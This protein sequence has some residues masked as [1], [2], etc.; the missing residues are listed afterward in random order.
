M[1]EGKFGDNLLGE[2]NL[3]S[4][5]I[6]SLFLHDSFLNSLGELTI[7]GFCPRIGIE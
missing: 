5:T 7:K 3:I 6:T 4:W 1:L 2:M